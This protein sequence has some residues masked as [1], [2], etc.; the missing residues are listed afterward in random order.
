M[1]IRLAVPWLPRDL[2]KVLYAVVRQLQYH[3]NPLLRLIPYI[4]CLLYGQDFN[5]VLIDVM[6][7]LDIRKFLNLLRLTDGSA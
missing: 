2:R 1:N 3:I 5:N 6:N 7:I 4:T